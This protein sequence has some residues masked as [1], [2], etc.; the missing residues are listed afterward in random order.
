MLLDEIVN[1]LRLLVFNGLISF[2]LKGWSFGLLGF[3]WLGGVGV[4]CGL[5]GFSLLEGF[6]LVVFP[7]FWLG[8]C[9][10]PG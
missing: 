3:W 4:G 5:L 2:Y 9:F 8:D 6:E 7:V 10:V 1:L